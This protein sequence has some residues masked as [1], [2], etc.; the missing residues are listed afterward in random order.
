MSSAYKRCP[1]CSSV[2]VVKNGFQSGRRRF[3]CK[4]CGLNFQSLKQDSRQSKSIVNQYV[5]K[6]R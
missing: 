6:K 4:D 3:K 2:N 5:F 1:S